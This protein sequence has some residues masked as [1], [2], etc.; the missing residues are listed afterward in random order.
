MKKL[1]SAIALSAFIT[2]AYAISFT[3]AI[4]GADMAGME[5]TATFE[6]GLTETLTWS[7]TSTDAS[8]PFGEGFAGGGFG[9]NFS[10]EHQGF[11]EGNVPPVTLAP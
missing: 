5:V 3:S 8:V 7:T 9:T 11:T 1:I 2:P 6:G 10:F 4:T